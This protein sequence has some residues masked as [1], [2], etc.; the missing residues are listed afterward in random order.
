M[1]PPPFFEV[2]QLY[3]ICKLQRSLSNLKQA[4]I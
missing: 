3:L 2:S 1:N 4:N